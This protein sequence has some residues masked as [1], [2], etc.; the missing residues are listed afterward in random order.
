M[1]L[2]SKTPNLVRNSHGV[3]EEVTHDDTRQDNNM[4]FSDNTRGE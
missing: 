2:S 1:N 3:N 4:I